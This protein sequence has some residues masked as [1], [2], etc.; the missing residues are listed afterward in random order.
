MFV[1]SFNTVIGKIWLES[2]KKHLLR[3]SYTPL[4]ETDKSSPVIEQAKQEIT[5]YLNGTRQNFTVPF[6]LSGSDFQKTVWKK[7]C[8]IPYGKIWSYRQLAEAVN[9]PTAYRAVGN[10]NHVN[11][12]PIIVPCHRVVN[13]CGDIGGYAGGVE[14]KKKLLSIEVY[15]S[16]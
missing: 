13:S 7:L 4:Q 2:D 12:L 1:S 14:I 9:Q 8:C 15:S 5:E 10:A 16:L 6:K 11:P 3:I